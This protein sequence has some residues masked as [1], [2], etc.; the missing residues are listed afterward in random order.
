MTPLTEPMKLVLSA[1][2]AKDTPNHLYPSGQLR[3]IMAGLQRRN[4]VRYQDTVRGEWHL[5]P[6]GRNYITRMKEGI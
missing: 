5:T 3:L 6:Q 4:L 1:I 2:A